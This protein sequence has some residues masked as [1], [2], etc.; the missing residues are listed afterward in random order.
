M[1]R[2]WAQH[3]VQGEILSTVQCEGLV[4]RVSAGAMTHLHWSA[5]RPSCLSQVACWRVHE[6]H[7]RAGSGRMHPQRSRGMHM[8]SLGSLEPIAALRLNDSFRE[9][10]STVPGPFPALSRRSAGCMWHV[11]RTAGS[12]A[13]PT[14]TYPVVKYSRRGPEADG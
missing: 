10:S 14:S 2:S 8:V 12:P 11:Q 9:M 13:G 7:G 5:S 3:P 1:L 4:L 6:R